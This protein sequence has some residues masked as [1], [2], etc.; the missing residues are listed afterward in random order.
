[1]KNI[2]AVN[3]N[4]RKFY[5]FNDKEFTEELLTTDDCRLRVRRMGTAV[6]HSKKGAYGSSSSTSSITSYNSINLDGQQYNLSV[7]EETLITLNTL[8]YL[9]GTNGKYILVRNIKPFVKQFSAYQMQI[10]SFVKERNIRFDN[11]NDLKALLEYCSR[12]TKK[13]E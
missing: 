9:V 8:Y 3:I 6:Q 11:E 4:N 10:E 2:I 13:E 1:V 5:P 12:L 7:K